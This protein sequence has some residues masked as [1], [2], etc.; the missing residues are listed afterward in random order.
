[1]GR[2]MEAVLQQFALTCNDSKGP[3]T[4]KKSHGEVETIVFGNSS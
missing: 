2:F 4:L 1:M 3:D